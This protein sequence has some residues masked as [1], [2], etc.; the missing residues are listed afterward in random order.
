MSVLDDSS[1]SETTGKKAIPSLAKGRCTKRAR[2]M[3]V[4]HC[5]STIPQSRG[6][7]ESLLL[8]Q[9]HGD[10][11]NSTIHTQQ[12]N[13]TDLK[14]IHDP[15]KK[16]ASSTM[17][18]NQVCDRSPLILKDGRKAST[19]LPIEGKMA[20]CVVTEP[21]G[22]HSLDGFIDRSNNMHHLTLFMTVLLGKGACPCMRPFIKRPKIN[23]NGELH[24]CFV[25]IAKL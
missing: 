9:T 21:K 24:S 22:C 14:L 7:P 25:S 8:R 13:G 10:E 11:C 15:F 17:A 16:L 2:K 4:N 20:K 19:V 18:A 5:N 1:Q 3:D 12:H 6:A 23:I